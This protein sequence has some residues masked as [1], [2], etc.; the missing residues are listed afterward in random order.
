ME[1]HPPVANTILDTTAALVAAHGL[2]PVTMSRIAK[3]CGIGRATV[4]RHFPD[5]RAILVAW[6]ERQVSELRERVV[7]ELRDGHG[8]EGERLE[9]ALETY[10]VSCHRHNG[11][12]L[13]VVLYGGRRVAPA[14]RQLTD[15]FRELLADAAAAGLL[16]DDVA[17]DELAT[18]C[19]H[20]LTA[21]GGL[22]SRPAVRR[23]VR[24]TLA[25]IRPD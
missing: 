1:A 7:A 5:V 9:A 17:V 10:G 23:L 13:A 20:A 6:Q 2:R 15:L 22:R 3:A 24:V 18:Y 16:R 14:Q 19:V 12:E 25:A 4:Y 21:A 8:G 11:T